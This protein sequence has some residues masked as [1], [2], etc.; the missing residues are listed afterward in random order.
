M[1]SECACCIKKN[2]SILS[3][4]EE[5]YGFMIWISSN[6]GF[7]YTFSVPRFVIANDCIKLGN[8]T[9]LVSSPNC[10][11]ELYFISE[12]QNFRNVHFCITVLACLTGFRADSPEAGEQSCASPFGG[13]RAGLDKALGRICPWLCFSAWT[14]RSLR[15]LPT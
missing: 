11:N 2:I 13:L 14:G 15:S 8:K 6:L 4:E 5:L 10:I 3:A 9:K 1:N 7:L 12:I